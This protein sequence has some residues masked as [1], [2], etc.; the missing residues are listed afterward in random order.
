[1]F[2]ACGTLAG[3]VHSSICRAP[4]K[5]VSAQQIKHVILSEINVIAL[6]RAMAA[7]SRIENAESS[8]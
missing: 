4:E 3:A 6:P 2:N 1:M 7:M 5:G 8:E